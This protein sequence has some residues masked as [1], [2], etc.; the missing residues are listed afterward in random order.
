MPWKWIEQQQREGVGARHFVEPDPD[1]QL[2]TVSAFT[3]YQTDIRLTI[4]SCLDAD[5]SLVLTEEARRKLKKKGIRESKVKRA[6]AKL[7][8]NCG[9]DVSGAGTGF[10][11]SSF[12][13]TDNNNKRKRAADGS[14]HCAQ[15]IERHLA[16]EKEE[17]LGA[18]DC[19][20]LID[21]VT[22]WKEKNPKTEMP[23]ESND[24]PYTLFLVD[25]F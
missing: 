9:S 4:T 20:L 19:R 13:L 23:V 25:K 15:P 7:K 8:E 18:I 22:K 17:V 16:M 24:I 3:Q 11:Y 12:R 5:Y 6:V 14:F 1:H 21:E 10:A 2:H